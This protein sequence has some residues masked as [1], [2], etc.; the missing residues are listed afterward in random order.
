M[1]P[2]HNKGGVGFEKLLASDIGRGIE[3]ARR[4]S[5]GGTTVSHVSKTGETLLHPSV[6]EKTGGKVNDV[7]ALSNTQGSDN[8]IHTKSF[9]DERRRWE[10]LAEI[11]HKDMDLGLHDVSSKPN[12]CKRKKRALPVLFLFRPPWVR[13]VSSRWTYPIQIPW[14]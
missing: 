9:Y 3:E 1:E 14:Q 8:S 5:D 7:N 2:D 10:V 11:G 4:M 6:H 12:M 13:F